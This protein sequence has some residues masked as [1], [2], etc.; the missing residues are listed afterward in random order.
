RFPDVSFLVYHSGFVTGFPE[1][2]YT[3]RGASDGIDTL[4]RSLVEN[5]IKPNSNVYAELGSTWR[6]LMRDPDNAA[7]ALGKLVQYCG[8]NN[9]PGG[10]A[11]IWSASHK[12]RSRRFALSRYR[13][14]CARST[15]TLRS[16]RHCAPRSLG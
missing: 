4:I 16:H 9:V 11:R 12:T 2:A 10:T 13:P 15:A 7:H 14:N 8:E 6:F 1:R 5:G 3:G